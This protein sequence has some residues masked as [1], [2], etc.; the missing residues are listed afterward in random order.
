MN[1]KTY[2]SMGSTYNFVNHVNHQSAHSVLL[3]LGFDGP[4][5]GIRQYQNML[6]HLPYLLL[7]QNER[8]DN[9]ALCQISVCH[10][11]IEKVAVVFG[12]VNAR[13]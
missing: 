12:G 7:F 4:F 9:Q 5:L 10:I 3:L 1:E 6:S 2:T 8:D 11:K 13:K